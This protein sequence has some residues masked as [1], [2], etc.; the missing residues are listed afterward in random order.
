[1]FAGMLHVMKKGGLTTRPGHV[2]LVV[3]E[4]VPAARIESPTIADA[5]ELAAQLERIVRGGVDELVREQ[6][7]VVSR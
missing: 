6:S 1:M 2:T 7:A 3:H 5:R 4:P